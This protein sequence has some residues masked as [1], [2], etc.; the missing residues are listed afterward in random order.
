[1]PDAG[2][3]V[4]TH[5]RMTQIRLAESF[6]FNGLD[7]QCRFHYAPGTAKSTLNNTDIGRIEISG[8]WQER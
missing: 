7:L 8:Q 3:G 1:M 4:S 6:M 5:E 2:P